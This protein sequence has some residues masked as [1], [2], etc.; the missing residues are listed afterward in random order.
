MGAAPEQAVIEFLKR[1]Y[2]SAIA[3]GDDQTA[4]RLRAELDRLMNGVGD[5]SGR[6]IVPEFP[7]LPPAA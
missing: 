6:R 5:E 4:T 1:R 7:E 3:R 2:A